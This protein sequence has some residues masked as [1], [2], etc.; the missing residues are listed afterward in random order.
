MYSN[1]N[2]SKKHT[3]HYLFSSEEWSSFETKTKLHFKCIY[4]GTALLTLCLHL[5]PTMSCFCV[6]VSNCLLFNIPLDKFSLLPVKCCKI[7]AY[8]RRSGPLNGD[9]SLSCHTCSDT[10]PR[11]FRLHLN[12]D[13]IYKSKDTLGD[14]IWGVLCAKY[15]VLCTK[16]T[17][18]G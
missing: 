7:Y 9:G 3:L 4:F 12:D 18:M 2:Y 11:F 5:I 6:Q 16:C 17:S 8:I 14:L 13:P 1:V 15:T 10:G